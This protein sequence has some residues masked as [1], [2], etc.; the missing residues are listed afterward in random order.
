MPCCVFRAIWVHTAL[1]VPLTTPEPLP[2]RGQ[3]D[4][5][6]T[7]DS[8]FPGPLSAHPSNP[9]PFHEADP[10]GEKCHTYL[11][12]QGFAAVS[13]PLPGRWA[14][15]RQWTVAEL[16][17]GTGC[18]L[19]CLLAAFGRHAT[20]HQRLHY[21]GFERDPSMLD[22][23]RDPALRS[24]I[25]APERTALEMIL[26]R[27]LRS[28]QGVNRWRLLDGR[29]AIT[30]VLGDAT[31]WLP[32]LSFEADA[33]FLDAYEPALETRLWSAEVLAHIA[34]LTR[35]GGT[36]STFSAAAAVR[37]GLHEAGFDVTRVAGFKTK[38]HMTAAT[39]RDHRPDPTLA[40][41]FAPPLPTPPQRVTILGAGLAGAW[42]ARAFAERG[43]QLTV[44]EPA[45]EAPRASDVPLAAAA[46]P[47]GSWQ[48]EQVRVHDAAWHL[49]ADRFIDLG[50]PHRL[51]PITT[52]NGLTTRK[53]LVA[54]PRELIQALLDHPL[55]RVIDRAPHE[56]CVVHATAFSTSAL[57]GTVCSRAQPTP[58]GGSIGQILLGNALET[59]IMHEGYALPN[60]DGVQA[61][62][63]ATNHPGVWA[64][65]ALKDTSHPMNG[66]LETASLKAIADRLVRA[67]HPLIASWSGTR[68]A[69]LDHLPMVGPIADDEAFTVAYRA[70]KHGPMAQAWPPCPY[71]PGQWCSIGH[72]SHGM[73]TTPLAA[74]L[75]ADLA[76]GTPRS[77]TDELLP[78]LFPQRFALRALR[79]ERPSPSF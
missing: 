78:F 33:W 41:W 7:E 54:S 14:A 24:G 62:I 73:L 49:L 1:R 43:A 40:P 16:G 44:V 39:R 28:T 65:S 19:A 34:R 23:W 56:A 58:N 76:Y 45:P 57:D 11:R 68:A 17:I 29:A 2:N 27:P 47:D 69:S 55:I 42:C 12:A 6:L 67:S 70:I 26:A 46:Q 77:I 21:V 72:G 64:A 53:A 32:Q 20:P 15:Q 25:P 9:R 8:S 10:W 31:V 51:M 37:S 35:P 4:F 59:A 13:D 60:A 38:R 22:W 30:L 75:I 61:W 50:V 63:G 79:R 3:T 52:P 48:S 71:T 66:Q 36:A 18:S 5:G 74:E